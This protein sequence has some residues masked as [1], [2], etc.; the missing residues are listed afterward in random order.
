MHIYTCMYRASKKIVLK[1]IT[2]L[3]YIYTYIYIH[4]YIHTDSLSLLLPSA[5]STRV[6]GPY[7]RMHLPIKKKKKDKR[8]NHGPVR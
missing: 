8:T 5:S 7:A 1:F 4:T 6:I 2:C 3:S